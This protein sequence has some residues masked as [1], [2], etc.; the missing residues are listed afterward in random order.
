M[1]PTRRPF[2]HWI[3]ASGLLV[4]LGFLPTVTAPFD[5]ADD[6]DLVY[7]AP[8]GSN[9]VARWW[10]RVAANVD[11]LGP[12]RPTLWAHWEVQANTLNANPVAWRAVRLLWCGLAAAAFL[13]LLWELGV[14]PPAALLA[15]AAA[16]WNPYRNEVWVSLTLAEGVAMPYL[17]VALA[18]A[19]RAGGRKLCGWDAVAVGS[20]LVALGCKNTFAAVA[21]ALL[22]LRRPA[23]AV[24]GVYLA[25]LL[26]PAA[27]FVYFKR[28]WHPGQYVTPGPSLG[29]L[30]RELNWLKGAAGL[31]FLGAGVA[32][33]LFAVWRER[34]GPSRLVAT[35]GLDARGL[36]W[37]ALA[38]IAGGLAAYLPLDIM[39]ARYTIPAV[40]GCDLLLALL[41][42]RLLALPD[43]WPRRTALVALG[44]GLAVLAVANL[45]RQERVAARNRLLWH[46]VHHLEA[47][48]PNTRV[49]WVSDGLGAEE[50]IH[51]AWHLRHRGR[52]DIAIGLVDA[53]D[54]PLERVELPPLAGPP[55]AR[56]TAGP[57][58]PGWRPAA[59][60]VVGYQLGRKSYTLRVDEP[61][62]A[63]TLL[64]GPEADAAL[65][66]ALR[67][68]GK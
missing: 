14:P 54:Q 32:L 64:I 18:A 28:N 1:T 62:P 4:A 12:F 52:P 51:A 38:L 50:G 39:A 9:Y 19:R 26:L 17:F 10:D 42:A 2:P 34:R 67:G 57:P 35:D 22:V 66:A 20:F 43:R 60:F 23:R 40:W 56:V 27:H 37:T 11:H 58:R 49:E 30:G 44:I 24:A 45:G 36:V 41:L 65:R 7:P 63:P 61:A 31:D 29:Q 25:P 55:T 68:E 15:C 33:S 6:G 48:P 21:P 47:L 16:F 3:L 46:A 5:F 59:E 53:A 13:W 8:A